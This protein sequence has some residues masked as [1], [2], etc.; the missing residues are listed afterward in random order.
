M[1]KFVQIYVQLLDEGSIEVF[2][3][4]QAIAIS[5]N[6]Y[7][8]LGFDDYD[9]ETETWEFVPGTVVSARMA[10]DDKGDKFLVATKR[11]EK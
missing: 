5:K 7:K 8:I 3:P 10:E 4:V 2:R 9:P 6:E 1:E 11:I